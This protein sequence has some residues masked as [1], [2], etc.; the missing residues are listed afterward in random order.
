M[1]TLEDDPWVRIQSDIEEEPTPIL[2]GDQ[3]V[4]AR[5]V[6]SAVDILASLNKYLREW[7]VLRLTAY[8]RSI[9]NNSSRSN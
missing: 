5:V 8:T 9:K 4:R 6:A 1:A 3:P 7:F 2:P